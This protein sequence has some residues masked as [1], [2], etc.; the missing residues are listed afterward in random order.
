MLSLRGGGCAASKPAAHPELS[1]GL[2]PEL[3]PG[4]GKPPMRMHQTAPSTSNARYTEPAIVFEL[5]STGDV[6]LLS[7]N[8]LAER[9]ARYAEYRAGAGRRARQAR[10]HNAHGA[11]CR[12]RA[13]TRTAERQRRGARGHRCLSLA[14]FGATTVGAGTAQ[15]VVGGGPVHIGKG[16]QVYLRIQCLRMGVYGK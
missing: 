2:H 12:A 1:P 10:A 3:S 13:A 6:R 4:L 15:Q 5:A 8:W 11:A 7:F 9:A 14:G 16:L